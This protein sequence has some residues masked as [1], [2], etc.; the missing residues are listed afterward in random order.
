MPVIRVVVPCIEG[1]D[2]GGASLV[3]AR[4]ICARLS[5]AASRRPGPRQAPVASQGGRS[6]SIQR[7]FLRRRAVPN[8]MAAMPA[9]TSAGVAGSGTVTPG[10]PSICTQAEWL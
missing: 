1:A 7:A 9:S 2:P 10:W 3:T 6:V 5:Q 8:A 4:E